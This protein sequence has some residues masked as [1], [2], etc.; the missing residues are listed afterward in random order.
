VSC[1]AVMRM[2][3]IPCRGSQ[4]SPGGNEGGCHALQSCKRMFCIPCRGSQDSPGGNECVCHALVIMLSCKR[5]FCRYIPCRGSQD[6]PGG[7]EGVCHALIFMRQSC[8]RMF[9][10]PWR[11]GSLHQRFK[12]ISEKSSIVHN[13]LWFNTGTG[14][15][16]TFF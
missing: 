9:R 12:G 15:Y 10:I 6:S 16:L 5:M 3:C 14:T 11:D 2:F 7:N 13:I 4:Y 1:T 8:K